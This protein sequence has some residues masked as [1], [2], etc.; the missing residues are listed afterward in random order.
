MNH[1]QRRASS[2]DEEEE[3]ENKQEKAQPI[4]ITQ[5]MQGMEEE[6]GEQLNLDFVFLDPNPRQF[7][8]VKV[9]LNGYLDGMSFK[10]SELAQLVIDQP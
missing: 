2:G 1:R 9:F 5:Q 7:T 10:S 6:G 3:E 4:S 8:S